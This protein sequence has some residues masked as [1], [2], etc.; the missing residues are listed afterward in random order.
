MSKKMV[1]KSTIDDEKSKIR[2]MKAVAGSG[3][4][5]LEVNKEEGKITAVG[6]TDPVYLAK[7]LR[8]LGY[9]AE[10]LSVGPAKEEKKEEE[11]KEEEKIPIVYHVDPSYIYGYPRDEYPNDCT[12]F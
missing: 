7:K 11:K 12:I 10:L 2:A 5:S 8:K 4:E 9:R 3:V 1:F 6:E